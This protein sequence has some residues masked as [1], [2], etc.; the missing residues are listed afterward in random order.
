GERLVARIGDVEDVLHALADPDL[1]KRLQAAL[2][3]Q[4]SQDN[5][6]DTLPTRINF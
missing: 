5:G 4:L 3:E 6:R 2:V 1:C